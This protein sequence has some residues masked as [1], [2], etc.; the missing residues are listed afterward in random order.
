[1]HS[2]PLPGLDMSLLSLDQDVNVL[3]CPLSLSP[4]RM[5]APGQFHRRNSSGSGTEIGG[6]SDS[7]GTIDIDDLDDEEQLIGFPLRRMDGDP[8]DDNEDDRLTALYEACMT[9]RL[10]S[11]HDS[12]DTSSDTTDTSSVAWDEIDFERLVDSL[13]QLYAKHCQQNYVPVYASSQVSAPLSLRT[14]SLPA[15][16]NPLQ[17]ISAPQDDSSVLLILLALNIPEL[18]SDPWNPVPRILRAVERIRELDEE[19][20]VVYLF[21]P[22]L[23]PLTQ[24]SEHDAEQGT[25]AQWIDFFRQVLE[26]LTFLHENDIVWGG[27]DEIEP[28]SRSPS[29]PPGLENESYSTVV[30]P[31]EMFM[32]DISSDPYAFTPT[33]PV[34]GR[35]SIQWSFDRSKYPVKYYFTDFCRSRKISPESSFTSDVQSCG[36]WLESLITQDI[37]LLYSHFLPLTQS[38]KSGRFT[39][40]GARKLFEARARSLSL[41]RDKDGQR[42]KPELW[43]E[44]IASVKWRP[45]AA[46]ADKQPIRVRK[47]N[48]IG[49][50]ASSGRDG[51]LKPSWNRP[52]MVAGGTNMQVAADTVGE[53]QVPFSLARSKSNPNPNPIPSENTRRD[54]FGDLSFVKSLGI[55]S[56]RPSAISLPTSA[57]DP[58]CFV[59]SPKSPNSLEFETSILVRSPKSPEFEHF[60]SSPLPLSPTRNST[61]SKGKQA[62]PTAP[63]FTIPSFV[64]FPS[65][66]S[67]PETPSSLNSSPLQTSSLM[68]R[69][70]RKTLA[71]GT[72]IFSRKS[73]LLGSG[74][75][76]SGNV[77]PDSIP[78]DSST[79]TTPVVDRPTMLVRIGR[80]ISMPVTTSEAWG[81]SS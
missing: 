43:D 80:S 15:N 4:E 8:E 42:N 10:E 36:S 72:G 57:S 20:S 14:L 37:P 47:A 23:V 5:E 75:G 17:N 38:M 61:N 41:C 48:T 77:I 39:A 26:G 62:L 25:V 18:R 71:L 46:R 56:K 58:V 65:S 52:G 51:F 16:P 35:K 3:G 24:D 67:I 78:E 76:V 29:R 64:A 79:L 49:V 69:G 12:E 70:R 33:T 53:L 50:A 32:M 1:M 22:P 31:A 30:K 63:V 45:S 55:G 28:L 9:A 21:H 60:D 74:G 7:E 6:D 2:D 19:G 73:V 27:F 34:S 81:R 11:N 13:P 68:L 59:H 40:D 44:R 66:E 54:V